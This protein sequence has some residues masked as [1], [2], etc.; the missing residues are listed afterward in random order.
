MVQLYYDMPCYHYM[1]KKTDGFIKGL[2]EL[3]LRM[4]Y[5][6]REVK[7]MKKLLKFMFSRYALSA[8]FILAE[9]ILLIYFLT[10]F[11]TLKKFMKQDIIRLLE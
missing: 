10:V 7:E 5:T 3:F 1:P 9:L 2:E 4:A 11:F 6:A 8:V